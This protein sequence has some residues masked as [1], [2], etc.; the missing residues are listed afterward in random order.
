MEINKKNIRSTRLFLVLIDV[1]SSTILT[2]HSFINQTEVPIFIISKSLRSHALMIDRFCYIFI[3]LY[4]IC[5]YSYTLHFC[6]LTYIFDL[7]FYL[8]SFQY[9]SVNTNDYVVILLS[10]VRLL[11]F[12]YSSCWTNC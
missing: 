8:V 4:N 10:L 6:I 3:F 9:R 2:E 12:A 5:S 11:G 7:S 1:V